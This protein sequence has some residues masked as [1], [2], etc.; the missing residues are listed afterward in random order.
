MMTL[1]KKIKDAAKRRR[2]LTL[3]PELLLLRNIPAPMHGVNP[4]TILG[5]KWWNVERQKAYKS[6]GYR[7]LACGVTKQQAKGPK[8]LEGHED[9]AIDYSLGTLTFLEVVPLCHYC[10]CYIHDG[11]LNA[12]LE[13]GKVTH[14]KYAAVIQHGDMVLAV[15]KLYRPIYAKR[16]EVVQDLLLQGRLAPWKD[17]RMVIG[18]KEY[19]PKFKTEAQWRKAIGR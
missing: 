9:Y 8:W 11:R 14:Q 10:H 4:R 15:A 18:D 5:S 7:C 1:S 12:M 13:Q 16:S 17:W 3:R 6:T 19:K 2:E